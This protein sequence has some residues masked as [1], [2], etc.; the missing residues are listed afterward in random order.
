M[1]IKAHYKGDGSQ[2]LN[3]VPARNLQDDEYEALDAAQRKAVRDS[4]LYRMADDK[5]PEQQPKAPATDAG[6]K[7]GA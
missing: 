2:F 3:G 4:G 5:P 1:A 7:G 6:Q